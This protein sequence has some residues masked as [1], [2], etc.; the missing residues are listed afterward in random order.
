MVALQIRDVPESLHR[1]L[2]AEADKRGISLQKYLLEILSDRASF[3][4][5][6][7]N[8]Q[9]FLDEVLR[10]SSPSL[11]HEKIMETINE[12]RKELAKRNSH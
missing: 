3:S 10:N 8:Q 5:Q 1:R 12:G 9:R 2:V 4:A 6:H 11:S 7:S